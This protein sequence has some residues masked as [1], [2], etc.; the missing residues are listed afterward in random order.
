MLLLNPACCIKSECHEKKKKKVKKDME[1][2][3]V[4][5]SV[6]A[7]TIQVDNTKI[8]SDM[9]ASH[10][11]LKNGGRK[12]QQVGMGVAIKKFILTLDKK[13]SKLL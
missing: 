9:Q 12:P 11:K 6:L 5:W 13:L 2:T 4:M 10:Q 7:N 3:N 1:R 8:N